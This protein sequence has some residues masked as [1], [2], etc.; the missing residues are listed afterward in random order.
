MHERQIK[1]LRDSVALPR[2]R[3][4]VARKEIALAGLDG[5]AIAVADAVPKK[6]R[7]VGIRFIGF[8]MGRSSL[9]DWMEK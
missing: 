8:R 9:I 1:R 5:A 6:D 3:S 7:N 4:T 2:M